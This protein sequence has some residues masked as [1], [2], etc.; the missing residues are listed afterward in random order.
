MSF[1]VTCFFFVYFYFWL[2]RVFVVAHGLSLVAASRG[3]TIL[4]WDGQASRLQW[5]LLLKSTGSLGGTG[6]VA[7]W[8]VKSSQPRDGTRVP[9]TGRWVLNHW[10]RE[11]QLASFVELK[12]L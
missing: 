5:F 3:A 9:N 4:H 11:V 10:T 7:L 6:L 1:F 2:H 8:H 12:C